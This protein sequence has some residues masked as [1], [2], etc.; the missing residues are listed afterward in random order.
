MKFQIENTMFDKL[1]ESCDKSTQDNA[2][3]NFEDILKDAMSAGPAPKIDLNATNQMYFGTSSEPTD[4]SLMSASDDLVEFIKNHEGFSPVAYNGL[5]YW[6][7]TI[8][9]GHVI[10]DD[11]NLSNLTTSSAENLLKNDLSTYENSVKSEFSD[12]KL[13]QGQYDA[14][15]SFSYALGANIWDKVPNLVSD[16]KSGADDETIKADFEKCSHVDSK[17]VDGVVKRRD[18]EFNMFANGTYNRI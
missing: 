12:T 15:V 5:D 11:E 9:Y 14:L 3:S 6:N 7:D 13:T 4:T 1:C 2:V 16:I 8:G 10:K 17:V 18:D